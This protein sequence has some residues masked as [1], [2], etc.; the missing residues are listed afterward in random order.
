[1]PYELGRPQAYH[2]R[3]CDTDQE[4]GRQMSSREPRW[5]EHSFN[6]STADVEVHITQKTC[7]PSS[8]TKSPTAADRLRYSK[9][10]AFFDNSAR[11]DGAGF[12]GTTEAQDRRAGIPAKE[13]GGGLKVN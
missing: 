3:T 10:D 12:N 13:M 4:A 7:N 9:G 2:P 5:D 6:T 8:P 11:K 1:M